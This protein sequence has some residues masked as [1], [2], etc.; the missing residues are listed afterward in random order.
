M[1]NVYKDEC[2]ALH[3][4]SVRAVTSQ[5]GGPPSHRRYCRKLVNL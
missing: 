3:E 1:Q 4:W 2:N 5:G